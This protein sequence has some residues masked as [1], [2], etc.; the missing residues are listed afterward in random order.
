MKKI[1]REV[2]WLGTGK[3]NARNGEGA[4]LRLR[5]GSILYIYTE[6]TSDSYEDD[7]IARIS[8]VRSEDEG[9]TWGGHRVL[10]TPD[11]KAMNIMSVSCMRMQNGDAGMFYLR[12][13]VSGECLCYLVRSADEGESWSAPVCCIPDEGY[14]VT[15]N[16]RVVRLPS[17]RILVPANRH[18]AGNYAVFDSRI[19]ASDDDGYT[20][21]RLS[22]PIYLPHCEEV[23][24]STGLQ[25]TGLYPMA[26]G[27]V[28]A[29]YRTDLHVQYESYSSDDGVTW[30]EPAPSRYFTSP[31]SPLLIKRAGKYTLAIWNP[32][33]N[34]TGRD[35]SPRT[36]GRTPYACAVSEDDG[37]TFPR[38]YLLE[39]DLNEAYCYPAILEGDGYFLAAY[40]MS[41]GNIPLDCAR[42]KKVLYSEIV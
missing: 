15:N 33:P 6:Y 32:I 36:W 40:Y 31:P 25:E 23:G 13:D 20:W 10:L 4:F 24:S 38:C 11:E 2:C 37:K 34:Y 35:C 27:R 12:K 1:G 22:E 26:D 3:G 7:A 42:I 30:T 18:I 28:R 5:D 39:D 16:D 41:H 19:Y 14:Y 29:Y 17:G 9:E 8:C 21:Y